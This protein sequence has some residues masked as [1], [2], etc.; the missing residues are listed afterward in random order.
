MLL[1]TTDNYLISY[2]YGPGYVVVS[3]IYI[4]LFSIFGSLF[5]LALIPIW[6]AVTKAFV[7]K[8]YGW[9]IKL[10][11]I[12]MVAGLAA[13]ILQLLII[14][15]L[16]PIV[17]LWLAEKAIPI[18]Y[19]YALIF[20]LNSTVFIWVAIVS[21]IANGLGKLK[22]Q[23]YCYL[24]AVILKIA[25]IYVL[26]SVYESWIIIIVINIVVMLPYCIIQGIYNRSTFGKLNKI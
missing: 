9:L 19:L 7:E 20:A 8:R 17:N 2:F 5:S 24:I 25:L 18:D 14:P 26:S 21:S 1:S 22:I 11:N 23:F 3:N 4:K 15:F 10:N 13:A 12:L 16:Q 6:S